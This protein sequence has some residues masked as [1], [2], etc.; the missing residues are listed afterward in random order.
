MLLGELELV[1]GLTST[2]GVTVCADILVVFLVLKIFL[3][4]PSLLLFNAATTGG[5]GGGGLG[6]TVR[7]VGFMSSSEQGDGGGFPAAEVVISMIG[8]GSLSGDW[9]LAESGDSERQSL[10]QRSGVMS[11]V[12]AVT[13][14]DPAEPPAS[15]S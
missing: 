10:I 8:E 9:D 13:P 6:E 2:W 14:G 1:L 4:L 3:G 7:F 12:E 15:F 11:E 5:G